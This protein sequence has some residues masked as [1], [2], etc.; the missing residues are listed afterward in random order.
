[1]IR[2][3]TVMNEEMIKK[4]DEI[5]KAEKKSRSHLLREAAEMF[6]REYERMREEKLRRERARRAVEV[7]ERL[8]AKAGGWD[9]VRV[10]RKIR[11]GKK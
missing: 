6:I 2:I 3:N 10:L 1:M 8:R 5:A 7:Q 9:G 11:E 4:L